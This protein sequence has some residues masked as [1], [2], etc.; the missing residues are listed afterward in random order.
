MLKTFFEPASVAV[1]GA[2]TDSAKLGYAV[3]QN[4]VEGG[5]SQRGAVYPINPKAEEILGLKVYPS[6]L[7]IPGPV[8]LAVIVVPYKFVPK[9]LEECG[10][11]SIPSAIVITAGFREA[12]VDGLEREQELLEIA[13]QYNMRLIGPNCLGVID[14][15]TP[16]NASFSAGT[17]P[18]GPMA[19]HVAIG[20]FRHSNFGLGS[21]WT[22]WF[23]QVCKSWQQ[24]R[25][26]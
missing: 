21:S 3:L 23:I 15:F 9:V 26:K 14:T 12:G 11:K 1:V 16:L 13:K 17:P 5:F 7:D 20:G 2:S 4:L 19:F 6:V 18:K 24:S 22:S 8:D 10:K 25:C